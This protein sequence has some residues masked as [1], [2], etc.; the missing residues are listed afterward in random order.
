MRILLPILLLVATAAPAAAELAVSTMVIAADFDREARAP[1][2]PGETFAAADSP[3]WCYTRITGAETPLEVTHVWY[4]EGETRARVILPVRSS[5]WRTWSAK[6]LRPAWV[7]R[8]EVK[9]LDPDGLVLAARS[10]T[11]TPAESGEDTHD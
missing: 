5:D 11:V 7:G 3:L 8:W 6:E 10:F 4:H 1:V 9:V 2:S